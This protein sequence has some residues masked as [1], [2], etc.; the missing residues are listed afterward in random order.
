MV[1]SSVKNIIR[2]LAI[3]FLLTDFLGFQYGHSISLILLSILILMSSR[4]AYQNNQKTLSLFC[5]LSGILT[6]L[7]VILGDLFA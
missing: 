2:V 4:Q 5:G 7:L 1:W 6:I 3:A